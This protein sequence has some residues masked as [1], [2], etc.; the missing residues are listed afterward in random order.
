MTEFST[1]EIW[2]LFR[3]ENG[4]CFSQVVEKY[5]FSTMP[6]VYFLPCLSFKERHLRESGGM[7]QEVWLL[8][9]LH[10]K[11]SLNNEPGNMINP[12]AVCSRNYE[13]VEQSL[14]TDL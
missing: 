2:V 11:S 6:I 4:T 9:H 13:Y 7:E 3:N 5:L 12:K 8:F 10:R 1:T 14:C